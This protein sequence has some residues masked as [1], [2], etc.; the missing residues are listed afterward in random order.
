MAAG[1]GKALVVNPLQRFLPRRVRIL[2][3]RH[4]PEAFIWRRRVALLGGG[5]LIGL[6][7]LLFATLLGEHL[8]GANP[9]EVF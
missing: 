3:R 9:L 6:V 4:G 8:G 5:T 7:A 2:L 1:T